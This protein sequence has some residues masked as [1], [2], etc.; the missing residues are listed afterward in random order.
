[1]KTI[2]YLIPVIVSIFIGYSCSEDEA[3]ET[4][5]A[6]KETVLPT[7][8]TANLNDTNWTAD[9]RKTVLNTSLNQFVITGT[10][11]MSKSIPT[12]MAGAR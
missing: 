10:S 2:K 12:Y 9:I 3:K 1:M 8:M 4:A 7:K 11:K 6:I 5:A